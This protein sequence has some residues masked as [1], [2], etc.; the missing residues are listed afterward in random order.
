[1]TVSL[2]LA[3]AQN[4]V[5]AGND[6]LL[7]IEKLIGSSFNDILTGN[8]AN[9]ML[10]GGDGNDTLDGG[11]GNDTL[12]GGL[13]TDTASYASAAAGVTA[14]LALAGAQNTVGAGSDTLTAIENLTGSSFDDVLTGDAGN[15]TLS[16]GLGNDT[17]DGGAGTDTLTGGAGNDTFLFD[18]ALVAGNVSTITD[19]APGSDEIRL[20]TTVFT[21]AGAAGTTLDAAAFF[22]GS[23][24][25]DADDRIIYDGADGTLWYDADGTGAQAATAF[26]VL[27]TALALTQNDFHLV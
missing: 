9:N 22:I 8:A 15:N 16:G 12:D 17:L 18:Q 11:A 19:F 23:A 14:S 13:G 2:A 3:G 26:A 7:N 10:I 6:T 27:P 20:S 24:A 21:A 1:V 5:G 4:T 25:H